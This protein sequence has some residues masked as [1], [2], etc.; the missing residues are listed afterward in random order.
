MGTESKL[1]MNRNVIHRDLTRREADGGAG[2]VAETGRQKRF[3][4]ER[5]API[6]QGGRDERQTGLGEMEN[7]N[8]DK[9]T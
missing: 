8:S 4:D 5:Q 6:L 2:E 3:L 1:A 7:C 9:S